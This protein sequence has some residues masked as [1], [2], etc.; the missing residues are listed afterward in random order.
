MPSQPYDVPRSFVA[1]LTRFDP[2][3]RVRWDHRDSYWRIERRR[4]HGRSA[5]YDMADPDERQAR[6]EG[7]MVVLRV[8]YDCLDWQ[9]FRAL[10]AGDIKKRGGALKV[11]KEMEAAELAEIE[12]S[13]RRFSDYTH[14]Q[15]KARWDGWNTN[16][17]LTKKGRSWASREPGGRG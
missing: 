13:N 11:A 2:M 5:M 6:S 4:G 3:L 7:Y 16:Y 9:V 10:E 17:P 1:E 8:P 15:A 12:A 14:Y